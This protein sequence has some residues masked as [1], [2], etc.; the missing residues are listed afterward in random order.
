MLSSTSGQSD[1]GPAGGL[2]VAYPHRLG[3][4]Y[5]VE[6]VNRR[7]NAMRYLLGRLLSRDCSLCRREP[8]SS[9]AE[10][11]LLLQSSR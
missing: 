11:C 3:L 9:A 1:L 6:A 5:W 8:C 2:A 7:A 4:A 10:L